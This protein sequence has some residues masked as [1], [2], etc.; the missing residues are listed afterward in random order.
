MH[1]A[2][3]YRAAVAASWLDARGVDVVLI[4]DSF[5]AAAPAGLEI[6]SRDDLPRSPRGGSTRSGAGTHV[7][8]LTASG[9]R[10]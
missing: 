4:D 2:S 9:M 8:G 10:E 5:S 3:G 7:N 1:C 6:L